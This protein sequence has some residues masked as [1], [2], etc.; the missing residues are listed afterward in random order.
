MYLRDA[1]AS[2]RDYVKQHLDF[3]Q[4]FDVT[5]ARH[6]LKLLLDPRYTRLTLFV[7]YGR[8]NGSADIPDIKRNVNAYLDVLMY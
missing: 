1:V 8:I 5:I 7:D 4:E 6:V 2:P 3:L